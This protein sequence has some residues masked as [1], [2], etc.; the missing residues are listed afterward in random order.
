M[1]RAKRDRQYTQYLKLTRNMLERSLIQIA[2]IIDDEEALMLQECGV[3]YLGFP[4]RLPV[5]EVDLTEKE[6]TDIIKSF[7]PPYEGVLITYLDQAEEIYA[8]CQALGV[9]IVQLH[10]DITTAELKQLKR[11]DPDLTIIKSLVIGLHSEETLQL[12]IKSLSPFVDAFI[13][14]TYDPQTG[15]SGATGKL[16]DW[17]VSKRFVELSERPVILAGGLNPENVRAAILA[18]RPA[19]VDVHTG[20]EDSSGRKSRQKVLKFIEEAEKGFSLL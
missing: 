14:D 2:G 7:A 15:A 19:G 18:V 5:N 13:T 9:R 10:G 16:H 1:L 11:I 20:V 12:T 8:F 6:A 4:L 3:K 17:Q